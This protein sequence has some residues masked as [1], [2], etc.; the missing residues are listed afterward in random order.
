M[1]NT[2]GVTTITY[3]CEKES[4]ALIEALNLPT[5]MEACL[6]ESKKVPMEEQ[7]IPTMVA[8]RA[9]TK[10]K[11]TK[12]VDLSTGDKN[13]TTKIRANL[14]PKY[15]S[16]LIKFLHANVDVFAWKLV[17]MPRVPWEL[18][19]HSLNVSPT[20]KPIKQKL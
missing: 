10:G 15:E 3:A 14:N 18:I 8:P 20:T 7:E 19:E 6:A 2:W 12:E 11:E 5:C 9:A 16:M 17:D 4:L 1:K 13:E